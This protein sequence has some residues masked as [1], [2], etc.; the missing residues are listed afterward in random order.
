[1]ENADPILRFEGVSRLYQ[2]GDQTV[3]ALDNV[4]LT[5]ERGEFA[6]VA[7]PSGSGKTTLLNI[8]A[9]LD[10]PTSGRVST[11]GQELGRLSRR[12]RAALRL[13]HVGFVFQAYNLVPV[14]SAEEN[15]EFLLL[16]RGV[17]ATERR[18]R[19][20]AVLEEVGLEGLE[21]RRPAQLSGGQQ[22]RVAVARAIVAEPALVLADEPTANLDSRTAVALLDLMERLNRSHDTTFLF[23]THDPRVMERARRNIRM[24]DGRVDHDERRQ[25]S[26]SPERSVRTHADGEK[27]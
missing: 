6:V 11:V 24:V 27:R 13:N 2:Q 16:L 21:H 5:L 17:P 25:P 19:V 18:R 8:A 9:G 4:D 23:S 10:L 14:L 1:M 26:T 22:Q 15:T 3:R 20:R 12:Q 7:G